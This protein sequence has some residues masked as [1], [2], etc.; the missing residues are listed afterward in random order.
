MSGDYTKNTQGLGRY[1]ATNNMT[2]F[3]RLL[4]THNPYIITEKI[5]TLY[6]YYQ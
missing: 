3:K 1:A 2:M 4:Q 6:K 5:K